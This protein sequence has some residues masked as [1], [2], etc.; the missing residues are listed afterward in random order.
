VEALA[1]AAA[2]WARE[3]HE[4]VA[5][6]VY[7]DPASEVSRR[8]GNAFASEFTA[9]GGE[10]AWTAGPDDEGQP[11]RP[12]GPEPDVDV[13]FVA[14]PPARV[15]DLAAFGPRTGAAAFLTA[16]GWTWREPSSPDASLFHVAFYDSADAAAPAAAFREACRAAG[17]PATYARALGWDAGEAVLR[18]IGE[19][20]AS[21]EGVE[22]AFRGGSPIEGVTGRFALRGAVEN[23]V[24]FA[25]EA[26]SD[27]S[28]GR[29][30]ASP[31]VRDP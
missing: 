3:A 30:E 10:V 26:D 23:P 20:G 1:V 25:R 21:R 12:A 19:G 28:L 13:V 29:V 11:V 4:A 24:V 9:L 15:A 8:L 2:V 18:A 17:V 6:G 31:A 5:A 14:G 27:R 7:R 22:R 16:G